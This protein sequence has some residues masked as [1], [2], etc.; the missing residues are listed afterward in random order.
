MTAVEQHLA[1]IAIPQPH[2]AYARTRLFELL[3]TARQQRIVWIA[4]PPGAGKTTLVSSYLVSRPLKTVWY[5]LDAS[6][7]DIASFFHYLALA[8]KTASPRYRKPLPSLRPEYLPGLPAFTRR[9]FETV[10]QRSTARNSIC[11]RSR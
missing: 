6:D 1:K 4:A 10:G 7:G 3:D 11:D 8:L 9:F 5:Q 2:R